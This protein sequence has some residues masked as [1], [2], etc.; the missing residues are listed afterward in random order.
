MKNVSISE[1]LE[2]ATQKIGL[3]TPEHNKIEFVRR[4]DKAV[5]KILRMYDGGNSVGTIRQTVG[6]T[7]AEVVEILKK[8]RPEPPDLAGEERVD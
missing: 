3:K 1:A 6:L 4:R 8:Y 7:M 5:R 2:I